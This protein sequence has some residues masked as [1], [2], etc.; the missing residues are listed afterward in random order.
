MNSFFYRRKLLG[1]CFSPKFGIRVVYLHRGNY[2]LL[3]IDWSNPLG[4]VSNVHRLYE[5]MPVGVFPEDSRVGSALWEPEFSPK[6]IPRRV[7]CRRRKIWQ[8][9][10][11]VVFH[12]CDLGNDV[13]K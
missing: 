4:A 1:K 11:Y 7:V 9:F 3:S 2:S 5:K 6:K 10:H 12:S 13:P 8:R